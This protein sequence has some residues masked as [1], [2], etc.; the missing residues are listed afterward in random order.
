MLGKTAK[1]AGIDLAIVGIDGSANS[2]KY[3]SRHYYT[4]IGKKLKKK[5]SVKWVS[6][7]E[8][9]KQLILAVKIRKKARHDNVDFKPL[10]RKTRRQAKIKRGIGDMGFDKEGNYALFEEEIGG[11]FIAPVRNKDVP[12][13]RTKGLHRK[14]LK[15]YFPKKKYHQRS[16]NETVIGVVKKKMGDALHSVKFHMRKIELLMRCIV[17][18]LDRLVKLGVEA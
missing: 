10:M 3:G 16:K 14:K 2:T 8:L 17:Y 12:V 13:W 1:M 9:K 5:D 15:R 18:N 7:V 6:V 11:E 4:R